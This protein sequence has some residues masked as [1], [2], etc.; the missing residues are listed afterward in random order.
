MSDQ[1]ITLVTKEGIKV[2]TRESFRNLSHLINNVLEDSGVGEEI[3]I[4][5]VSNNVLHSILQ[6]AEHHNF[7]PAA[8][9]KKPIPSN[10]IAQALEDPWDAEFIKRFNRDEL[11]EL[12]LAV[13]YLD[14]RSLL[15]ICF[16]T[17]ASMFKGKNIEELKSEYGI[18]EEFTPEMEEQLKR[19]NEWA[20]E[21]SDRNDLRAS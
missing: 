15:D 21:G 17:I 7:Q 1:Q 10:D 11:I 6:F 18:T 5:H 19:E 2:N 16:A 12:L 3:P 9:P 14:M 13:N 8:P 4:E 20:L